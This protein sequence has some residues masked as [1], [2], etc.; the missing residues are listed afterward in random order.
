MNKL[1]LIITILIPVI[2][3][4][5]YFIN[6]DN[7]THVITKKKQAFCAEEIIDIPTNRCQKFTC[8]VSSFGNRYKNY[9]YNLNGNHKLYSFIT[10]QDTVNDMYCGIGKLHKPNLND[11]VIKL[12]FKLLVKNNWLKIRCYKNNNIE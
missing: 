11:S 1:F 5:N 6:V 12:C 2:S 9:A 10:R 7:K 8:Q 4:G 3:F